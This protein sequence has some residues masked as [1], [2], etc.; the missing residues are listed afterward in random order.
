MTRFDDTEAGSSAAGPTP[1]RDA[2]VRD[3]LEESRGRVGVGP[4]TE[5]VEIEGCPRYGLLGRLERHSLR[6]LSDQAAVRPGESP[7]CSK[8]AR[9]RS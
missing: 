5:R 1:T 6:E 9:A 7:G 3:R 8:S 2:R 4:D